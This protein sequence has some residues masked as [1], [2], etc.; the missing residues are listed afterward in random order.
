MKTSQKAKKIGRPASVQRPVL[1]F[2]VHEDVY[3]SLTTNAAKAKRSISEEAAWLI[4]V[5]LQLQSGQLQQALRD[6]G[7]T[8]INR[9]EGNVWAE[10]GA[11]YSKLIPPTAR[12][13]AEA[14]TEEVRS[15]LDAIIRIAAGKFDG[16]DK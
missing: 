14:M 5:G 15:Q 2:R 3:K 10:P 6:A 7:Y 16:D 12:Q 9:V 8:R 11:D 13:I 4:N 1:Q